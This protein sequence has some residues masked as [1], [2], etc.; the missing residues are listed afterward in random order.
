[1]ADEFLEFVSIQ[2]SKEVKDPLY[3]QLYQQMRE[4]MS[5]G[6][7]SHGYLLP[8]VRKFAQFLTINTGTVMSAYKLLEKNGYIFSRT[9]SGSYVAELISGTSDEEK[10]VNNEW[11]VDAIEYLSP[12][13]DD[14][15]M[16]LASI[17]LNP[18]LISVET[19]KQVLIE[20]LDRD[21]GYAF[22]YQESQGFYPLR[23]S[24]ALNLKV[25]GVQAEASNMQ[26]ISGAQQGIDI[27]AK[28]V[29][30]YGDY[31]FMENPTYPGAIAAFRSRGAK[32]V[33]IPI[34]EDGIAIDELE[35][36]L[37]KFR[38][39]LIYVMPNIQNPT[40]YSYSIIKRNRLM[41]LA[42]Y[43][44]TIILE[45]DYIS[46]LSYGK[47]T[48]AP[49]KAIDRDD[50]VIYLK[51]FSKI[52][53]PGLRLAFFMMPH[54]L[55][56]KLLAV[57]HHSDI[58]T[59]GLTQ[60]AFDLYLRKG[61]WQEHI[62]VIKMLYQEKFKLT[63][64]AMAKHIPQTVY[65]AKPK[66]G[67]SIWLTLPEGM[68]ACRITEAARRRGVL[69]TEGT[70]FFPRRSAAD[71]HVRVSFATATAEEIKNGIRIIGKEMENILLKKE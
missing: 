28:A 39:K 42:R 52:F 22:S 43:Y 68:S 55:V 11:E 53:M 62:S 41:G 20:V 31:V 12:Q 7:L 29:L 45:D 35:S 47:E 21:Q 58:S 49:L 60:R 23:C 33:T 30:N 14:K 50:R 37:K 70:P 54:N 64:E 38:P 51:S 26:I 2:L 36:K 46:E 61:I 63:M 48:M 66:G 67:L 15:Y 9:G 44:N 16:N 65:I 69:I 59:S 24:I 6:K 5:S 13:L 18:D 32:I 71:R 40:G 57:K 19:F 17:A 3:V 10:Q 4:L 8:P 27:V 34:E 1:M 25:H 56:S